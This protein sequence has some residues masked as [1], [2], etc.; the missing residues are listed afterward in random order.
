M[1]IDL[2]ATPGSDVGDGQSDTIMINATKGADAITITGGSSGISI[3]GLAAQINIAGF[4]TTFDHLVINGLA[5]DDVIQGSG[6]AAGIPF[7]ANGGDGN[8]IL[9]G[10]TG[11]DILL[12]GAGD[13]VLIGGPGLDI[14]DGGTGNNI[15]IQS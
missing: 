10:G 12:G 7:T 2:A 9:I 14:L 15:L 1:N 13:D 8:D 4:E 3:V 6:L 5:G 11:N